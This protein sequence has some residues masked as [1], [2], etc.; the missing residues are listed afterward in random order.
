MYVEF[1]PCFRGVH[2]SYIF[3][4]TLYIRIYLLYI[5]IYT[6]YICRNTVYVE[7]YCHASEDY[8]TSKEGK[9]V[10]FYIYAYY[11]STYMHTI[12]VGIL[13]ILRA[14]TLLQRS[15]LVHIHILGEHSYIYTRSS[16]AWQ[17]LTTALLHT[18]MRD[19]CVGVLHAPLRHG[20]IFVT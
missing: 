7:S 14:T 6:Y 18:Y 3:S 2:S 9:K 11:V 20:L 1:L 10:H 4:H 17:Q 8:F 19:I 12:H 16:E 13:C 5:Y 15:V